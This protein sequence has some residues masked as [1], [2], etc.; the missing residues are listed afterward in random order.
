MGPRAAETYWLQA[1]LPPYDRFG[2]SVDELLAGCTVVPGGALIWW[3]VD[4][5]RQEDELE[6]LRARPYGVPL[7]VL[8]PSAHEI[9]RTLPL[10]NSVTSLQP[11]SVLPAVHLGSP[12]HLRAVLSTPPRSIPEAACRYLTRRGVLRSLAEQREVHRIFELAP[13]TPSVSKLARRMYASR[14]TIGRH[15]A[16]ASLPVPSHWLQFARLLHVCV[17]LQ[18]DEAAIFRIA[19]RLGYPDG[20]TM[21]NQ[22]KRMIGYRPSEVREYLGWEWI[23]EAWLRREA[24]AGRVEL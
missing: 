21:S 23:V 22:M 2:N 8:L 6:R 20:F 18:T 14:R 1:F 5:R 4:G 13:E 12:E 3:L 7:I 15:F 16:S 11:R 24:S 10:L 19:T 9:H 17:Q